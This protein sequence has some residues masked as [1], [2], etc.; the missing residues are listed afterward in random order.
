MGRAVETSPNENRVGCGPHGA[1]GMREWA[2]FKRRR[3]CL[4]AI[5]IFGNLTLVARHEIDEYS[6]PR[7]TSRSHNSMNVRF[8]Q[9][10]AHF[11]RCC[12]WFR[13]KW[14]L[15]RTINSDELL[16]RCVVP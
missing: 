6:Q 9:L 16:G 4:P 8:W 10:I 14:I 3:V 2:R 15:G 7:M 5:V 12:C 11:M 13:D 1:S